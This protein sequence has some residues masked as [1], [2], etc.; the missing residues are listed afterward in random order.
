MEGFDFSTSSMLTEDEELDDNEKMSLVDIQAVML[1]NERLQELNSQLQTTLESTKQQ[2]KQ[3]LDTTS[4]VSAMGD[5]IQQLRQQLLQANNEKEKAINQLSTFTPENSSIM[6]NSLNNINTDAH[7]TKK[8]QKYK[9]E[10]KKLMRQNEEQNQTID[11]LQED[12]KKK[13]KYKESLKAIATQLK[14]AKD[15]IDELEEANQKLDTAQKTLLQNND[16]LN[17]QLNASLAFKDDTESKCRNI[18]SELTKAQKAYDIIKKQ[19]ET[20]S[21]EISKLNKERQ[22]IFEIL[23]KQ[24]SYLSAYESIISDLTNQND[25]LTR[26]LKATKLMNEEKCNLTE[27]E[28]PF[29]GEL[30]SKCL[31][32]LMIEQYTPS[33]HIQMI[34][35]E[36]NQYIKQQADQLKTASKQA[37]ESQAQLG[38]ERNGAQKYREIMKSL[39]RELKNIA[40]LDEKINTL[41]FCDEDTQ[42]LDFVAQQISVVD[43]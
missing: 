14:Q 35:N 1:E 16:H 38:V 33:H 36:A 15:R 8:L 6:D 22:D 32:I 31:K 4:S 12:Q 24:S 39:L 21:E 19:I 3:A 26:K 25:M 5:E 2:L 17:S 13:H 10:I 18:N 11:S 34:L 30:R 37:E 27:S 41:A 43:H 29:E 42:F 9:E 23:N 40:V 7:Q 20:Q 28:I